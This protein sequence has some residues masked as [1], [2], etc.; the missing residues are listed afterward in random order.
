MQE[1]VWHVSGLG[2]ILGGYI[3][4]RKNAGI[5][6]RRMSDDFNV[7]KFPVLL[8]SVQMRPRSQSEG[9]PL[10]KD[11]MTDGST[12]KRMY[13]FIRRLSSTAISP[14]AEIG[15]PKPPTLQ[16]MPNEEDSSQSQ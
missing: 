3:L 11:S 5:L 2:F 8:E 10:S 14:T 4:C 15:S 13:K 7:R 16:E 6:L 1:P 12:S 9:S